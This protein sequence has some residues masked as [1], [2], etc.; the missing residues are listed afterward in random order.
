M[1]SGRQEQDGESPTGLQ[2]ELGPQ[3][4]GEQGSDGCLTGSSLIGMHLVKGSPV[5]C[6]GQLQIGL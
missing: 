2:I 1:N 3:G 5:V 4:L 6:G